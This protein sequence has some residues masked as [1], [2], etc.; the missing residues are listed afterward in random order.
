M[1]NTKRAPSRPDGCRLPGAALL[2]SSLLTACA[3]TPSGIARPP[4]LPSSAPIATTSSP[5]TTLIESAAVAPENA[6]LAPSRSGA[7]DLAYSGAWASDRAIW[8]GPNGGF[9]WREGVI[10]AGILAGFAPAFSGD[11]NAFEHMGDTLQ[12]TLPLTAA[13][14]TGLYQD[15][16]GTGMFAKQFATA[17]SVT[18]GLK[19]VG[20]KTRP[21]GSN[22]LSF[23]S[24]HTMGAFSGA[25]FLQ[26]RYG[27][28]YGIPAYVGA[29]LTGLS[30][31]DADAHFM[32]D[33]LAGGSI[34]MMSSWYW[35]TPYTGGARVAPI[36]VGDG[37]GVSVSFAGPGRSD[38]APVPEP[39]EPRGRYEL[40]FGPSWENTNVVGSPGDTGTRIEL[41]ELDVVSNPTTTAMGTL[42][43]DVSD[44]QDVAIRFIPYEVQDVGQSPTPF[45]FK[46]QNFAANTDTLGRYLLYEL[47]ARWRYDL[48]PLESPW[49]L[50]VGAGLVGQYTRASFHQVPGPEATVTEF[51][52]LPVV[53]LAGS[54]FF[55]DKLDVFLE[56]DVGGWKD[57]NTWDTLT[58]LRYH[59]NERWDVGLSWQYYT[60]ELRYTDLYNELDQN[61]LLLT[62]G[63]TF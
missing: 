12:I 49:A 56:V 21:S 20:D 42:T 40:A 27:W 41:D 60:Q 61:R 46:G 53:H 33:V 11:E 62:F 5:S 45:D 16:Y 29:T 37:L 52:L 51:S 9:G 17:W 39:F 55:A 59:L 54:Y 26:R 48:L 2:A 6:F 23:P 4:S 1:S 10:T 3:S 18:Y 13:L 30:R 19:L 22:N 31:V 7:T 43:L 63:Y 24:G 32:D 34:A 35:T 8:E 28:L 14:A 36:V 15:W 47:R 57:V 50:D 38:Q 25:S 44:R 58:G